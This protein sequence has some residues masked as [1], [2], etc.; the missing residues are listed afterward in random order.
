MFHVE[1]SHN[2]MKIITLIVLHLIATTSFLAHGQ[3]VPGMPPEKVTTVFGQNIHYYEAGHGPAVI[4]LHGLAVDG[5]L[6]AANF[7][8]LAAK[9]HVY[10]PDQI[11]FGHSDKPLMD[12]RVATFVDFLDG[13]M[14]SQMIAKA[15]L[16]GNSLGGWIAIEFA[17][18]HPEKVDKLVLVDAAGLPFD[19]PSLGDLNTSSLAATR[20]LLQTIY[21][22][23]QFVTDEL[24][25]QVFIGHLGNND[26]YTTQRTMAGFAAPGQFEDAKKLAAIHAPTLV[27]WGKNDE[28]I[29]AAKGEQLHQWITGSK[30]VVFDQCGHVPLQEKPDEFNLLVAEF[31]GQ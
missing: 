16:V 3:A 21:Y 28:L 24:V 5:T 29:P 6:W 19:Q 14:Q 30:Y 15:S 17:L 4:L 23:K 25:R 8:P 10:A 20:T 9:Y 26:G 1:Q 11:G 27:I 31:L 18:Q 12:Y 2:S 22:N 13:F 7:A